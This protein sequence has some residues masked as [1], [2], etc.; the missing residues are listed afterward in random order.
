[1]IIVAAS[2]AN[3]LPSIPCSE[4]SGIITITM[5][6]TEKATGPRHLADR[7]DGDVPP[8]PRVA[9]LAEVAAHVLDDDDRGVHDHADRERQPAE[10]HQ[11]RGDARRG[12]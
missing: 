6:S 8:Q 2:G 4:K 11:V 12:P 10:A 9:P 7:L 5:I 1:M 3:I